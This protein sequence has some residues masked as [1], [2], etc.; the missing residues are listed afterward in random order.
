MRTSLARAGQ[1][2]KSLDR[3]INCRRIRSASNER[4]CA[5]PAEPP[6]W[7]SGCHLVRAAPVSGAE[8]QRRAVRAPSGG[9]R[10]HA[11]PSVNAPGKL[12]SSR[13][14]AQLS[15]LDELCAQS[16]TIF[17]LASD[18]F[19]KT[20]RDDLAGPEGASRGPPPRVR[21]RLGAES[22][23]PFHPFHSARQ[24]RGF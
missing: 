10:Y 16:I 2:R 4:E 20:L 13:P 7:G 8:L 12:I 24:Q 14:M 17:A 1:A 11:R 22:P 23:I 6:E 15:G 18:N 21:L 19:L 5:R 3:K 9:A